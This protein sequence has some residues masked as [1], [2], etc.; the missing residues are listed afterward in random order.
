[1]CGDERLHQ[2]SHFAHT[3][4]PRV[5][6]DAEHVRAVVDLLGYI[7]AASSTRW[8]GETSAL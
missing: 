5:A 3:H 8:N 6:L 2:R 1:M 4:L 7:L